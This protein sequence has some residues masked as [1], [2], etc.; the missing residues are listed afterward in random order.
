[1][2]KA[3]LIS[4][5]PKYV[6]DIL[7]GKKTIEIRKS[8]PKCD[9]PCKVHIYCTK[10]TKHLV[11]PFHFVEGWFYRV[12]DDNTSYANGCSSNIGETINGKVVAEFTLNKIDL[13]VDYGFGIHYVD[14][15]LKDLDLDF[16]RTNSCL[17]DEQIYFYLGLKKDSGYY[18]D[19]YVWH[20]DDLIIYDKPKELSEFY[21]K[22]T[23]NYDD[24]LF[25]L[26]NGTQTYSEYLKYQCSLKRPPQSWCYIKGE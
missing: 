10:D 21:K 9:L 6:A 19:G 14:K 16:L 24:F 15:E 23:L 18:N 7:N 25:A 22:N 8:M 20:I 5:K 17:T 4:I 3:I 2:A 1:M 12:Y 26:Y 11:A 13:L